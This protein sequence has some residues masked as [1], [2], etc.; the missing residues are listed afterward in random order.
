MHYLCNSDIEIDGLNFY[1][2]PMFMGDC[3]TERESRHIARIPNDTD[4]LITHFPPHGILDFD[5]GIYY[6]SEELLER[7]TG[8]R[9]KAHLFDELSSL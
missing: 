1:G 3:L 2:V 4:I 5:D 6:G 8:L 9:L 7:F